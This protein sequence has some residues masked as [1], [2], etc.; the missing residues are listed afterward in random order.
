MDLFTVSQ[1][2]NLQLR[3]AP[4][5]ANKNISPRQKQQ[6]MSTHMLK[7]SYFPTQATTLSPLRS[8]QYAAFG[9]AVHAQGCGPNEKSKLI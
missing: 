1:I 3:A 8:S 7:P 9:R 2:N 5:Q 4:A 6:A